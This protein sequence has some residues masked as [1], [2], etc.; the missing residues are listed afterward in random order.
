MMYSTRPL[1]LPPPSNQVFIFRD[2]LPVIVG[3]EAMKRQLGPYPGYDE[4]VNP[5]IANVFATAAFRFA[6]LTIQ[7][8]LFR[9]DEFFRESTRFPSFALFKGFSTPWRVIFEGECWGVGMPGKV[10]TR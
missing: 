9:L 6:H 10:S 1:S 8:T 5:S 2:Y 3:D 4:N 7:P